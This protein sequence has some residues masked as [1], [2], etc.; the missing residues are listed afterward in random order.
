LAASTISSIDTD[1]VTAE[2][3]R[4]VPEKIKIKLKLDPTDGT[5][6][7]SLVTAE[8]DSYDVFVDRLLLTLQSEFGNACLYAIMA[9]PTLM[10]TSRVRRYKGFRRLYLSDSP[11]VIPSVTL[12]EGYVSPSEGMDVLYAVAFSPPELSQNIAHLGLWHQSHVLVCS[13]ELPEMDGIGQLIDSTMVIRDREVV[14]WN[15][16]LLFERQPGSLCVAG[17]DSDL[18]FTVRIAI[19]AHEQV[20]DALLTKLAVTPC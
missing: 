20:G 7:T 15:R 4:T 1:L 12:H 14:S 5:E 16:R 8:F 17:F 9:Q 11:L 10:P 6:G 13:R 2:E 19:C 18:P 3:T